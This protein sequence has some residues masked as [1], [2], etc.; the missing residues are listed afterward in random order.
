MPDY[1]KEL[2][3]A[4]DVARIGG[5]VAS[6]HYRTDLQRS[7]KNDGSWVTEADL[8]TEATIREHIGSAWPDHNVLGE[9]EGLTAASGGEPVRGAPTWV[10]DPIDGTNNFMS[11]VPVWATLV[12]LRIDDRS[13]VGV[14]HAP[15][16]NE[17]YDAALGERARFNGHRIAVDEVDALEDATVFFGGEKGFYRRGAGSAGPQDQYDLEHLQAKLITETWRSRG[18]GDFWGH[19]LVARGAGHVML[20]PSVSLWDVAALEIILEEAGGRLSH[21][22]GSPFSGEGTCLS[23]NGVLHDTVVAMATAAR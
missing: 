23:S 15:A 13:I 3:F 20:E 12:A 9:E 4:I 19:M 11:E 8:A 17:T 10:V 1:S 14:A 2:Q 5:A 21:I 18:F 7:R 6:D 22:D 16:L